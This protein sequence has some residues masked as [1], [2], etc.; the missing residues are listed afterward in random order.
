MSS[1][2]QTALFISISVFFISIG[3]RYSVKNFV[4]WLTW[5]W[6]EI[7]PSSF[8]CHKFYISVFS[9]IFRSFFKNWFIH[10]LKVSGNPCDDHYHAWVVWK[11]KLL[12]LL[13][14]FT[15][16]VE[17]EN[18]ELTYESQF[19][20]FIKWGKIYITFGT[21]YDQLSDSAPRG[22]KVFH[23]FLTFPC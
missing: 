12:Q 6:Y 10:Q 14:Y 19:R 2:K 21:F 18:Y 11:Q 15:V 20:H 4:V 8:C 9:H 16:Q 13:L 23:L 3:N 5:F 7:V 17:T 1:T 22:H